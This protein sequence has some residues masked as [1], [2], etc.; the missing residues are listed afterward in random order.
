MNCVYYIDYKS[1]DKNNI[2]KKIYNKI[3]FKYEIVDF[4]DDKKLIKINKNYISKSL[5]K[6]LKQCCIINNRHEDFTIMISKDIHGKISLENNE[7]F[8]G[9]ILMKNM[10][11]NLIEYIERVCNVDFRCEDV[12]ISTQS[13]KSKEL[14]VDVAKKFKCVNIV[15]NKIRKL[16]RLENKLS[17]NDEIIFTI[18]NNRKKALKRAKILINI[19]FKEKDFEEFNINR[20]CIII[21]LNNESLKLK[22]SFHGVV[23]ESAEINY[24]NR[25][26][27]II[28][29]SKF[30]KIKLYESYIYN[31]NYNEAKEY[32]NNDNCIIKVLR[33]NNC[34][35]DE[36]EFKNNFTKNTIKLDKYKK[37]D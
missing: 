32:I 12:F 31:K 28:N 8:H 36:Y 24:K 35:I 14:I 4:D 23:V 20:Y 18:S 37:K 19:D 34:N 7:I 26:E 17:K 16:N 2:Y 22:N 9:K 27:D 5:E 25:Y 21:N 1:D 15:T 10:I 29:A 6:K 3:F 13:D 11:I 33:G 30:D